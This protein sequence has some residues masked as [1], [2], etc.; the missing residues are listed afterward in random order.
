MPVLSSL[1]RHPRVVVSL[2]ALLLVAIPIGMLTHGHSAGPTRI[3]LSAAA[4]PTSYAVSSTDADFARGTRTGVSSSGGALRISTPQGTRTWAGHTYEYGTWTSPWT[5]PGGTF[6]QAVPS[7]NAATP[8]GSWIQV[9]VRVR[10]GAG[11]TSGLENLGSWASGTQAIQRSSAG[12]QS[13][14]VA[15][16]ATDTLIATGAAL[17]SY[18]ITVRLMRMPGGSSPVLGSVG[19]VTATPP[20][21][22]PATSTP[23]RRTAFSLAVPTYS[24]M[25]HRGQDPQYGGGGEAWCSPTSLSM[26]LGYYRRLP[27]P[28]AAGTDRWVNVVARMTYD[29]AYDGTGNWPFNTAYAATRGLDTFVT[30]LANLRMA[31]R[32][33]RAGI[34]LEV[35]I[36]FSRGQLAGAPIS[37]TAGH[38]VVLVGFTAAGNPMVDDPAASSDAA[39]RRVYDRGQFERAWLGGSDGMAYVVHDSAHPLPGRPAGVRNW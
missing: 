28:A 9:L 22:L 24:Q 37:A 20:S 14:P 3:G 21:T 27:K 11:R 2:I 1:T 30:R 39:V 5:T 16:V 31:E 23:L 4:L 17:T 38:L 36:R 35:S 12:S 34:P 13:G 26:L 32:F 6:T 19:V 10:T 25:I 18:R 29:Y 15:R 8:A 33:V 7:W